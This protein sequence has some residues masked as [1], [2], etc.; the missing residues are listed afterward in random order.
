MQI[1]QR[2]K[3]AKAV[4]QK[5]MIFSGPLFE[6]RGIKNGY[7]IRELHLYEINVFHSLKKPT[8]FRFVLD[9]LDRNV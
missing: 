8:P 3:N 6:L 9:F 1:I 7:Y 5:I 4:N 2:F